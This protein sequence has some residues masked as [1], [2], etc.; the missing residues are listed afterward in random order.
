MRRVY[1]GYR[2]LGLIVQ[3]L[4]ASEPKIGKSPVQVP[5]NTNFSLMINYCTVCT[6]Y[7]VSTCVVDVRTACYIR[8]E[9]VK[10]MLSECLLKMKNMRTCKLGFE[11]RV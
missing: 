7:V 5:P 9:I 11:C 8:P 10:H 1:V 6:L 2:Q 4:G 3:R